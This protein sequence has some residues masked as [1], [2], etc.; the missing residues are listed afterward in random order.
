MAVPSAASAI[1]WIDRIAKA[2]GG[3]DVYFMQTA[4]LRISVTENSGGTSVQYTALDGVV[5][6]EGGHAQGHLF[7]RDGAEFYALQMAH[8]SCSFKVSASE[9]LGKLTAKSVMNLPGLKPIS[10]TQVIWT[11]GTVSQPEA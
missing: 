5:R 2:K 10:T 11:D 1:C 4:V 6:D 9:E 8:D 7:V 3:I